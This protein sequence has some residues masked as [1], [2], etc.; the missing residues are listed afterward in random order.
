M[1]PQNSLSYQTYKIS[2]KEKTNKTGIAKYFHDNIESLYHF[3]YY[4]RLRL[5]ILDA[6]SRNDMKNKIKA[7]ETLQNYIKDESLLKISPLRDTS[8]YT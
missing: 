1:C 4:R 7:T 8:I 2:I 6:F 5:G 3:Q